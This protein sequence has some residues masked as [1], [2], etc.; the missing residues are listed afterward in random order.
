MFSLAH[1][2]PPFLNE[3]SQDIVLAVQR[4]IRNITGEDSPDQLSFSMRILG[5]RISSTVVQD[6]LQVV[7]SIKKKLLSTVGPSDDDRVILKFEEK[8]RKLTSQPLIN[9]RW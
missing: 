7:N 8:Y 5:S 1:P 6:E 2:F 9:N 4:L 3:M